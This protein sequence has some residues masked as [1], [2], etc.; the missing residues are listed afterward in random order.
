MT[1]HICHGLSLIS[2]S[3][4]RLLT[5]KI[6]AVSIQYQYHRIQKVNSAKKK[7]NLCHTMTCNDICHQ[8][9]VAM[10]LASVAMRGIHPPEHLLFWIISGGKWLSYKASWLGHWQQC[11]NGYAKIIGKTKKSTFCKIPILWQYNIICYKEIVFTSIQ[12]QKMHLS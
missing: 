5:F 11:C 4:I 6:K 12:S 2:S 10:F 9:A 8:N 1:Y 7:H 3:F